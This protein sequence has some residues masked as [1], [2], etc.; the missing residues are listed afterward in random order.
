[1]LTE[2]EIA[3]T[4]QDGDAVP[5]FFELVLPTIRTVPGNA[6]QVFV[7]QPQVVQCSQDIGEMRAVI[8]L[9]LFTRYILYNIN[10][11]IYTFRS[12][13]GGSVVEFKARD[14]RSRV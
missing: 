7:S 12:E 9:I 10:R 5:V 2:L 4:F 1:M 8:N 11:C 6:S 13:L 14:L 3:L